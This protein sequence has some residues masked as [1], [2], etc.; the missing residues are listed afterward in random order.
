MGNCRSKYVVEHSAIAPD[1]VHYGGASCDACY[2]LDVTTDNYIETAGS[3]VSLVTSK[4][5]LRLETYCLTVG[6]VQ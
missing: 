1:G 4:V 2:V 5:T 6:A 3:T